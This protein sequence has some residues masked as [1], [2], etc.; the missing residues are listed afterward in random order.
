MIRVYYTCF[1]TL[2]PIPVYEKYFNY[3]PVEEKVKITRFRH[4]QD[5]QRCLLGKALLIEGLVDLGLSPHLVQDLKKSPDGRPYVTNTQ[6][7]NLD[8]NIAHAGKYVLCAVSTECRI[9]VD[10]EEIK[11]VDTD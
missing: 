8:F 11:P 2:L 5:A 10:I 3:M 7:N 1:S 4:W 9:G 6:E